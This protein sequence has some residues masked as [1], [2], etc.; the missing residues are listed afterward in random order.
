MSTLLKN[1]VIFLVITIGLSFAQNNIV[2]SNSE[3]LHNVVDRNLSI[4]I[5]CGK[6]L[7]LDHIIH[8]G[9]RTQLPFSMWRVGGK[10]SY[11]FI[12]H[13]VVGTASSYSMAK[14]LAGMHSELYP[15][16]ELSLTNISF[17]VSYKNEIVRDIEYLIESGINITFVKLLHDDNSM[18]A[19]YLSPLVIGCLQ[20][21]VISPLYL[22][23]QVEN[24]FHCFMK[25]GSRDI[26]LRTILPSVCISLGY[27]FILD[28]RKL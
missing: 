8:S 10:V 22:K 21:E 7:T 4:E 5:F 24:S 2:K 15:P 3:I 6:F 20:L 28:R 19:L 23:L 17:W 1:T 25:T 13:I 27:R 12:P 11:Q 14:N 18:N 16:P 9:S 26:E